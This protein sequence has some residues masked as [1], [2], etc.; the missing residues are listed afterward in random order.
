MRIGTYP[1]PFTTNDAAIRF[2]CDTAMN[3]VA[4]ARTNGVALRE[5]QL[6]FD[7]ASSKLDGYRIWLEAVQRR[8]APLPVTITTLPSW[9]NTAP[10]RRLA[11]VATNYVLQVHSAERPKSFEAD[12]SLCDPRAA[13]R[14]VERAGRIGV[15]FRVALPTYGYVLAFDQRGEFIS[16]AAEGPHPN[17]RQTYCCAQLIQIPRSWRNWCGVGRRAARRR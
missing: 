15:P 8:V 5:L 11:F 7:C 16:L 2:I 10:F 4:D 9:L 1:G 13:S 14:A 3:L 17:C 12:Y 6:D